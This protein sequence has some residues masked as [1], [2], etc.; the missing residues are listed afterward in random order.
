MDMP[1][2]RRLSFNPTHCTSLWQCWGITGICQLTA[3]DEASSSSSYYR[4]SSYERSY[5]CTIMAIATLS[6][7]ILDVLTKIK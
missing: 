5:D 2:L 1:L 6:I 4:K 3:N 7:Y